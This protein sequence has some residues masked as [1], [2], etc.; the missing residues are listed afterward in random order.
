MSSGESEF[1]A[2]RLGKVKVAINGFGRL[3]QSIYRA[4]IECGADVVAI[5]DSFLHPPN[6][7]A[8]LRT[9]MAPST[10][11]NYKRLNS[12]SIPKNFPRP[13][14]ASLA[15]HQQQQQLI[16]A[17]TSSPRVYHVLD[18][19]AMCVCES[20]VECL[21]DTSRGAGRLVFIRM[22]PSANAMWVRPPKRVASGSTLSVSSEGGCGMASSEDE[23]ADSSADE[24]DDRVL[25][26]LERLRERL[27]VDY[28]SLVVEEQSPLEFRIVQRPDHQ[29]HHSSGKRDILSP[30]T[31]PLFS[32]AGSPPDSP[33]RTGLLP[34]AAAVRQPYLLSSPSLVG[35]DM[36]YDE[37]GMH[38]FCHDAPLVG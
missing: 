18:H 14:L 32:P 13:T 16:G 11:T 28:R 30:S 19:A 37:D 12:L 6:I 29:H 8:K 21:V 9:I 20:E 7:R 17:S 4:S 27:S 10:T 2:C 1:S 25:T 33:T 36:V 26:Y 22:R 31:P 23:T 3:G 24:H 15:P 35:G 5:N 38:H 34:A